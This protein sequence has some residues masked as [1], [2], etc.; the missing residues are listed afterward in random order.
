M[1]AQPGLLKTPHR[2]WGAQGGTAGSRFEGGKQCIK[3]CF[4]F[5]SFPPVFAF[6]SKPLFS[7]AMGRFW[8]SE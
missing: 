1:S 2:V 7:V 4:F 6:R 8:M 5:F 3:K